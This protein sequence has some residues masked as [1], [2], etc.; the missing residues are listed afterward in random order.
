MQIPL[1]RI[2]PIQK[3][4]IERSSGVVLFDDFARICTVV[5]KRRSYDFRGD[6]APYR[7]AVMFGG[8]WKSYNHHF[9][10]QVAGCRLRCPYC[11]VDNLKTDCNFNADDLVEKFISF[12]A[13]ARQKLRVDVN[14]FHFMGGMPGKYPEF[15]L[16]LRE[17]L[18]KHGL[19]KVI[20]FSDVVLLEDHFF[21]NSPWNYLYNLQL[22]HFVLT[23][24][25]KGTNPK[26]FKENTG[27]DLFEES[28]VE[29]DHY[30]RRHQFYLT[31]IG[32]EQKDLSFL[33]K[34]IPEPMVD[35]L[36]I[37]NYEVTR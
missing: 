14:V 11:Y 30:S 13:M 5:K 16:E 8:S 24:C 26:N 35:F 15:W 32:F 4:D 37:V 28:L 20:L 22:H 2:G 27:F 3:V 29:L 9:I 18:D 12:K 17:S 34:I 23:G 1:A 19:K 10:V 7:M 36:T 25:L 33:W 21:K 31:L 6:F